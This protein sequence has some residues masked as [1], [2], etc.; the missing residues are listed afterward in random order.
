MLNSK[1]TEIA[2]ILKNE[3]TKAG[4]TNPHMQTA[5]LGI[6]FKESMLNPSAQEVSYAKTSNDRIRNIFA[7]AKGVSDAQLDALKKDKVA[8]FDFVYNGIIGNGPKDGYLFRGRGF[9]Q[10]TGRANYKEYGDALG[11]DLVAN[12][13]LVATPEIASK[14]LISYMKKGI[15]T[16]KKLGKFTGKDINDVP[17]QKVAYNAVYNANAGVA[18]NL[19]DAEGNIKSDTTGGYKTGKDSLDYLSK[20][21]IGINTAINETATKAVE[22][23]KKKPLTSALVA[24]A[25]VIVGYAIYTKF[26]NS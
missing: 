2:N 15:A 11:I 23:V 20:A 1:Q 16:L 8:F 18:K 4:I 5:I 26:K 6:A 3:M 7:K 17:D 13:D 9:N 14:V 25:L 12:P 22:E 10:L 21:I 19:Y 24:C